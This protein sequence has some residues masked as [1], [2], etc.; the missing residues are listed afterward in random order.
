MLDNPGIYMRLFPMGDPPD[1]EPTEDKSIGA[2]AAREGR[3]ADEILFDLM[4]KDEGRELVLLPFFNYS[5]GDLEPFREM[6]DSE[7]TVLSLGDRR[8]GEAL[9]HWA[10][11]SAATWKRALKEAGVDEDWI[12]Y[13]EKPDSY[14]FPWDFVKTA[15]T[16]RYLLKEYHRSFRDGGEVGE[17]AW[18]E[19]EEQLAVA[20]SS[21]NA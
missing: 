5:D 18:A 11:G 8:V 7:Q 1:Y 4:L 21:P 9:I 10:D 15:V 13:G 14:R 19:R 16:R 2:M 12:L 20:L 6:L 3:E 17:Q